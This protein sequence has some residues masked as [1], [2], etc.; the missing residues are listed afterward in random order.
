MSTRSARFRRLISFGAAALMTA[1]A[2]PVTSVA[3][4]DDAKELTRARGKFQ[5]ATELEQ[6]G[7]W[8]GAL[9]LLREVGQVKMTPQVRFHIA[10]C[11]E[12]L[13]KL[14]T[15]LGGYELAHAE[16]DD[17]GADF[18]N[19]VSVKI[20][21]LKGRI[22]KLLI[23]RGEGAQAAAVE[24]D[25]VA[26][27]AKYIGVELP[28]D[29]GPHTVEAKAPGR[30]PFSTTV[31]VVEKDLKVVK[32]V[33]QPSG[34]AVDEAGGS[35]SVAAPGVRDE[36][37]SK[38]ASNIVPLAIAGAG[39]VFLLASGAFFYLRHSKISDAE[40][41]CGAEPPNCPVRPGEDRD[42]KRD[43]VE[44][45]QSDANLY[46]TL[47]WGSLAVGVVGVGVGATLYFTRTASAGKASASPAL[48]LQPSAPR[49]HAGMSLVGRF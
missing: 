30:K 40:D 10:L 5:R 48:M 29:T 3:R 26:I 43:E 34:A 4:A 13:G 31:E 21:D 37:R 35:S 33:L 7:N 45:L 8:T 24:L 44:S 47:M 39:G 2:L 16:A 49:A 20:E 46:N 14:V 18:K 42:A 19:E 27:G 1:A 6:A 12:N 15:A 9:E 28:V 36:T 25:G 32:I 23:Q 38:A 22:P 41:L 11:E 17:V